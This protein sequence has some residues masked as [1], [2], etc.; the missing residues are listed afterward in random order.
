MIKRVISITLFSIIYLINCG[1][2]IQMLPEP[3]ENKNLLIGSIIFDVNGY[4]DNFL[5]VQDNI[6]VAIVGRYEEYGRIKYFGQW[7]T[8]D[9]NGHFYIANVPAGEYAVKGFKV[10]I[11]GIGDLKIQNDLNNPQRNY[12]ELRNQEIINFGASLFDTQSNQR[13]V[14]LKHNVFTLYHSEIIDFKRYDRLRDLKLSTGEIIDSPPVPSY[15]IEKF[16][17]SGWENY[18]TLQLR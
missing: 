9:E 3:L 5:T 1:T 7:A 4:Q 8:T 15:F 2:S 11:M 14:N 6:E 13:I 16:E 12:F 10:F 18:L 17:G